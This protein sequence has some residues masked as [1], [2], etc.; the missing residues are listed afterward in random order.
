MKIYSYSI[1]TVDARA[2]IHIDYS[3]NMRITLFKKTLDHLQQLLRSVVEIFEAHKPAFKSEKLRRLCT[4]K[5]VV[6]PE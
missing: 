6:E 1:K 2:N 3:W 5:P 4:L